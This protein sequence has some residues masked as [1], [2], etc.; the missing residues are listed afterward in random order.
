[1]RKDEVLTLFASEAKTT[2]K[3]CGL[4]RPEDV[5]A[6]NLVGPDL[7]GFVVDFPR[8]H[9]SVASAHLRS[10]AKDVRPDVARVGVFVDQPAKTIARLW[11]QGAIDCAQLHG[12]EGEDYL[13]TLRA[14]VDVPIV[15][16]FRMNTPADVRLAQRS[17]AD[18]VLL[19]GGQG[20][21]RTFDWSLV[22]DVRRPFLLAGGL[23]PANVVEAIRQVRPWGV[24]MS[25]GIETDG[26]KD[27]QKMKAA[28]AAVRGA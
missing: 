1:M 28:V 21:G 4:S 11:E 12:S 5:A 15:Q 17:S 14:L 19:D 7:V 18:L 16:A 25:T 27:I 23:G 8:S 22:R 26:R 2:I 13:E 3:L 10:L 24:D 9:R 6:A 20:A